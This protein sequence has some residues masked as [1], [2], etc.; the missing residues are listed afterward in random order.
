M[1][2][3]VKQLQWLLRHCLSMALSLVDFTGPKI[4]V[5][6]MTLLPLRHALRAAFNWQAAALA[7][8]ALSCNG[9]ST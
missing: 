1:H 4:K 3:S 2:P 7:V 6:D 5:I 8:D 9:T